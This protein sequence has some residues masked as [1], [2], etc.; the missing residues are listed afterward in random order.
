MC[1]WVV[2]VLLRTSEGNVCTCVYAFV[3]VDLHV[4]L[5]RFISA[6]LCC[7]VCVCARRY[8]LFLFACVNVCVVCEV[9]LRDCFLCWNICV[10]LCVCV[11]LSTCVQLSVYFYDCI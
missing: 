7:Y 2:I 4:C 3:C 5:L 10:Y 9:H 1:S 8:F 6:S 11:C